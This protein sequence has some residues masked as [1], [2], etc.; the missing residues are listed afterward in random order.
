MFDGLEIKN[1]LIQRGMRK[2]RLEIP[3]DLDMYRR[4]S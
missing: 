3:I 2:K 1:I 4:N